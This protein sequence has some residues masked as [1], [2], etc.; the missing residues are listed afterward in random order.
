MK[1]VKIFLKKKK[2]RIDNMVMNVTKISQKIK[3]NKMI[4][5]R[6]KYYRMINALYYNN[7]KVF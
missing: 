2:K 6:K 4:E 3:K 5:Y 7:K 1:G